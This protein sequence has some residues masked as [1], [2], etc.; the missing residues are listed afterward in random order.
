MAD[1]KKIERLAEDIR[2]N[3]EGALHQMDGGV[4]AA[5]AV[6]IDANENIH[7]AVSDEQVLVL[8]EN[9]VAKVMKRNGWIASGVLGNREGLTE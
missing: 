4:K 3:A 5:P 8:L 7:A 9:A 1:L 6:V 2:V